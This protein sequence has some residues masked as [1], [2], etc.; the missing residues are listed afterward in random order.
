LRHTALNLFFGALISL[1]LLAGTSHWSVLV[2]RP[3]L[4]FFGAISYGVYLIHM[5]VFDLVDHVIG[6]VRPSLVATSGYF[7]LIFLRFCVEAGATVAVAYASRWH[8]EEFFLR[9]KD[10]INSIPRTRPSG[11]ARS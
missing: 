2:N 6:V 7:G 3:P 9:L 1:V 10:T 11:Q 5:W 4:Q 8:F